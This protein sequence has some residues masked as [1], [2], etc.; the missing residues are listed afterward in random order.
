MRLLYAPLQQSRVEQRQKICVGT[1]CSVE[2]GSGSS[3]IEQPLP[4]FPS[5]SLRGVERR[6][7]QVGE[8]AGNPRR[9]Q[10][11][12]ETRKALHLPGRDRKRPRSTVRPEAPGLA[13]G[14][15]GR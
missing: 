10:P 11:H 3:G 5:P 4:D 6:D 1:L 7:D 14:R 15:V 13:V 12:V 2:H 8:F 9:K